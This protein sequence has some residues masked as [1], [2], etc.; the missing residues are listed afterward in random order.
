MKKILSV[1]ILAV[2]MSSF[3]SAQDNKFAVG[4]K[5]VN[6]GIGFGNVLYSGF[7]Y[8]STVPPLSISF[9][10]GI[11]D[12]ILDKGILGVGG[13]LGYTSWK[14]DGGG[15]GWKYS[16]LIVGARGVFHYPLVDN[17]DTYAGLMLGYRI[18]TSKS[19]GTTIGSDPY[20]GGG[21]SLSGYIGGRYYF[22][23]KYAAMAE[24]G[25]GITWLNLG[26]SVKL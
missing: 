2:I 17:I 4:D 8:K 12:G 14:W 9:E 6:V 7:G 13:Y 19:F 21:L 20:S 16:N 1:L 26:V 10:K 3:L 15:Y 5:V 24:L 25:Y 18:S 23:E 22:N 11:K